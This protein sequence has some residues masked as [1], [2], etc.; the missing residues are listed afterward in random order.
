MI[1]LARIGIDIGSTTVKAVV[2]DAD[3]TM[4]FLQYKRH[5]SD[6]ISAAQQLLLSIAQSL[7]ADKFSIAFTGS[8]G[9]GIAEHLRLPFVQEVVACTKAVRR[10]LP[11]ADAIIELGGEDAK[12][13]YL[14]GAVEQRMNG[15]CAGGTGAF[16]DQMVCLLN[17]DPDGF[18]EL[19][20]HSDNIYPIASRC[21]VLPKPMCRR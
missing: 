16:I 11:E 8:A 21:G 13:T 14:R 15:V 12:I 1:T 10:F 7:Q 20:R 3:D 19:S 4:V 5:C 9:M 17:T 2:L 18:N 6:V